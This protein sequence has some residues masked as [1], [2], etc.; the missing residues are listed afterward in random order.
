M[1]N[2]AFPESRAAV[3]EPVDPRFWAKWVGGAVSMGIVIALLDLAHYFP[4]V[5][6]HDV[7]GSGAILSS[8]LLWGGEG[9]VAGL[10]LGIAEHWAKPRDIGA[11]RLAAALLIGVILGVLVCHTFSIY[12]LRDQFG[13]R[14]FRDYLGQPVVWA[15]GV[16]YHGWLLLFF[17][18]LAVAAYASLRRRTRM[19]AALHNAQLVRESMRSRLAQ[20]NL[21]DMRERIDPDALF[22]KLFRLE[23]LYET[24]PERADHLLDELI[25]FLRNA[26]AGIRASAIAT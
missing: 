2:E 24:D 26:L 6:A 10:T 8:L 4:L 9:A 16:L 12:V 11:W 20:A 21:A 13:I 7:F 19:V 17:G 15:G 22:D 18:G 3:R 25:V 1:A 5:S 23:Q 14:Q